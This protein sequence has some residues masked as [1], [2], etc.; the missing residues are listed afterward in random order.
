MTSPTGDGY[1]DIRVKNESGATIVSLLN[2]SV[3]NNGALQSLSALNIS[4]SPYFWGTAA[5]TA[6]TP[7]TPGNWST[8]ALDENGQQAYAVGYYS[9]WVES[10]L[11]NMKNNYKNGGV[12]YTTKTI[13]QTVTVS[14]VSPNVPAIAVTSPNGGETWKGVLL[15]PS[16]G[17]IGEMIPGR[18]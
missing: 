8:G 16:H 12:Y 17:V 1:L 6:T 3:S 11:N 4:F 7:G 5:G 2:G 13:S 9:A 14:L 18:R 15:R 10:R